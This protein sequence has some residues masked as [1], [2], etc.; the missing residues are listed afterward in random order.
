[1]PTLANQ[2][3]WLKP[4]PLVTAVRLIPIFFLAGVLFGLLHFH[5]VDYI[6]AAFHS[7]E[8]KFNPQFNTDP[9]VNRELN[10]AMRM[11]GLL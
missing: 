7:L 9:W 1:M 6:S 3:P 8:T 10:D 11:K 2:E 5:V 4:R